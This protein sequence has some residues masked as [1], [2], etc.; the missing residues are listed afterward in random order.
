MNQTTVPF[1][2]SHSM[3][4]FDYKDTWAVIGCKIP[5]GERDRMRGLDY[6][7]C[8]IKWKLKINQM[9]VIENRVSLSGVDVI[10]LHSS[11]H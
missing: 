4:K 5:D 6:R 7:E 9:F 2:Q 8:P 10:D 11:E 3:L 1:I